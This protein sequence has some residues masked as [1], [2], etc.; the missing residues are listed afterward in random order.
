MKIIP[1]PK[2]LKRF[3]MEIFFH[4]TPGSCLTSLKPVKN[5]EQIIIFNIMTILT[6]KS[7]SNLRTLLPILEF[8]EVTKS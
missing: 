7:T 1:H 8:Q 5:K 4:L 3:K 2:T 6:N